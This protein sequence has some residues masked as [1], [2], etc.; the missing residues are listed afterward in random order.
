MHKF[1]SC[2]VGAI[3][4]LFIPSCA[5]SAWREGFRGS[6]QLYLVGEGRARE[7]LPQLQRIAMAREA[8][9]IDAMSHWPRYCSALSS[10]DGIAR[11]RVENQKQRLIECEG[12]T[13][14]ARIVIERSGLKEKCNSEA[15]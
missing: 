12:T 6:D 15:N 3:A 5:S 4:L 14:R 10:E 1:T 7:D 11:F 2:F 13:C 9:L 8:A